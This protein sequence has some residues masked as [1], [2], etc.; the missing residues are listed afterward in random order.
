[1]ND[2]V[3]TGTSYVVAFGALLADNGD[4]ILTFGGMA[5]LVIRLIADAPRAWANV[6]GWFGY[7]R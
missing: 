5:L 3:E 1:M 4:Q 2:F 6:K 7:D